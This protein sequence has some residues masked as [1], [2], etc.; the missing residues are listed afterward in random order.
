MW[1]NLNESLYADVELHTKT[2][3]ELLYGGCLIF[4]NRNS[5]L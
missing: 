2:K 1:S 4:E 5:Y 3:T